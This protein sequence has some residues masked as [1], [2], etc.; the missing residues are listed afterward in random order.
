[1]TSAQCFPDTSAGV[2][3]VADAAAVADTNIASARVAIRAIS[4][5]PARV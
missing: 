2:L 1:M 4:T 3:R 5:H